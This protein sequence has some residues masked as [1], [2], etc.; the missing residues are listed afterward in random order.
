MTWGGRGDLGA[1]E[2][3]VCVGVARR[4]AAAVPAGEGDAVAVTS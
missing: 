3:E 2:D 1:K 4:Q